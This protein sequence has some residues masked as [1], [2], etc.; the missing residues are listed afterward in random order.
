VA[1]THAQICVDID[2]TF[3]QWNDDFQALIAM[4]QKNGI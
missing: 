4:S 1:I 3:F 2:S